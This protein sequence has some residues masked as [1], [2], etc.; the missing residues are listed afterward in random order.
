[1]DTQPRNELEHLLVQVH[2]GQVTPEDFVSRLLGLQVFMP[3]KDEKHAIAGFQRSTKAEPLVIQD[4]EGHRALVVFSAPEQAKEILAAHPDYSG[5]LLTEFSWVLQRMG[6]GLGITLNPGLE[7][8]FDFDPEMVAMMYA[9][10]PES[11]K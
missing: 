11:K 9:L 7:L 3:V 1:M 2:G 4:E 10:L 5:G 8:G 6:G